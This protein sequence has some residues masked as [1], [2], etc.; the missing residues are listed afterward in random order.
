MRE[1]GARSSLWESLEG[2]RIEDVMH[3]EDG[4]V[5]VIF[6]FRGTD[7]GS[8]YLVVDADAIHLTEAPS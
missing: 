6:G 2:A 4:K 8:G 3:R 7:D 1:N 5:I